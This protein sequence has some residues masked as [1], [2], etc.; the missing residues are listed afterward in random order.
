MRV[1]FATNEYMITCAVFLSKLHS[2]EELIA[3][4]FNVVKGQQTLSVC[5]TAVVGV[6]CYVDD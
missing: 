3:L 5:C 1:G 6:F 2:L 4:F